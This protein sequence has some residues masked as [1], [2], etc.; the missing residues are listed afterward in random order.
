MMEEPSNHRLRPGG[1]EYGRYLWVR[2]QIMAGTRVLDVGCNCGQLAENLVRDLSCEVVGVDITPAF[3]AHCQK[4]KRDYGTF[5]CF[6]F[7]QM[8]ALQLLWLGKFHVVTA[9]EVIE[10]P[11]DIRGFRENV[12]RVL[13]P[14]GRLII[15]TPHPDSPITGY[16]FMYAY[17]PHVRMW[18]K[19]RLEVAFGSPA[20][21]AEITRDSGELL[22]IGATFLNGVA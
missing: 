11:M 9:L 22:S 4:K 18:T 3:I 17:E 21:Y 14:G 20:K 16:E 15:T 8:T 19:R 1:T 12:G 5:F 13:V 2:D 6:D 7:S 10:H